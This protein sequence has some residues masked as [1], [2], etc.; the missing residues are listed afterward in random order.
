[1]KFNFANE[2]ALI[3]YL[4]K[5]LKLVTDKEYGYY[6][7]VTFS[8]KVMLNDK[9]I[10]LEETESHHDSHCSGCKCYEY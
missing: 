4:N 8:A 6:G 9:P 3:E 1:M 2:D 5:N 7:E 10:G